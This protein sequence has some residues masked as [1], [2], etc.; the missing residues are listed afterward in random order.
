MGDKKNVEESDDD[1]APFPCLADHKNFIT[2][3]FN[4]EKMIS[5]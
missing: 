5:I 2:Y 3:K 1:E 4:R